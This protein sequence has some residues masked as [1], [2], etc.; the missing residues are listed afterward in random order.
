MCV[1][2]LPFIAAGLSAVGTFQ[3]MQASKAAGAAQQ[4]QNNAQSSA[5]NYQAQVAD[6]NAKIQE[7]N[8]QA[9]IQAGETQQQNQQRKTAQTVGSTRAAMAS[10]G[11]DTTSGTSLDVVSDEAKLGKL[12]QLTI[13]SNAGR[14]AYNYR[15]AG[16]SDTAQAGLDRTSAKNSVSAG[17]V[18]K[19]AGDTRAMSTLLS[20][21]TSLSDKFLGW[22]QG[23]LL[24]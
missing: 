20:G 4:Q 12:D 7:A 2:A 22:Q 21:A 18:A 6:N 17:I 8:A 13:R 1:V 23:G 19:Q 11:I 16:M 10:N 5:S 15:V 9:V 14:E 24:K 3:G